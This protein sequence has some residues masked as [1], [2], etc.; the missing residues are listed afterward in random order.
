M[1]LNS[2]FSNHMVLQANKPIRIFGTGEGTVEIDFI[3]IHIKIKNKSN[4]W[5]IELPPLGYGGP[6]AMKVKLNEQQLIFDDVYIGEVIL[7][8][9]QSNI[10]LSMD[11]TN[12]PISEYVEN[13]MMRCFEAPR[14]SG[15]NAFDPQNGWYCCEEKNISKWS[16]I[17]YHLGMEITQRH[18]VAVGLIFCYYGSSVIGSWLPAEIATQEKYKLP[19]EEMYDSEFVRA[20]HNKFGTLY[21]FSQQ[22]I[23]PYSIGEVIW[24]QGESNTGK[25]EWKIYSDLLKELILCWRNDFL[26]SNLHFTVIQIADFDVRN[27]IGW[28]GI[29]EAQTKIVDMVD[30]V[31]LVKSADLCETDNIH[32]P[33]KIYLANRIYKDVF[34]KK[35]N[36]ID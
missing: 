34:K 15:N 36:D 33:T 28:K 21:N 1:K 4:S 7:L 27:D 8:A 3:N 9:G 19:K 23:V 2:I 35:L 5:S 29:Q 6:Y 20:E 14:F 26:E 16:A 30:N 17:G 13:K 18:N 25:G 24:Y 11:S 31:S 32:P 12:F 10:E 22:P